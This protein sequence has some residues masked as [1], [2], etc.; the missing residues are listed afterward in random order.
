MESFDLLLRG[1]LALTEDAGVSN[2]LLVWSDV[3]THGLQIGD[4]GKTPSSGSEPMKTS[5]TGVHI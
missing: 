1:V 2:Y 3:F 5:F 4:D